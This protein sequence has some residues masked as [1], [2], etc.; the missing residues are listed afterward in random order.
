MRYAKHII[1]RIEQNWSVI[2]RRNSVDN[3]HLH[4]AAFSLLATRRFVTF[5]P[6]RH[7]FRDSFSPPP[8]LR[9]SPTG[10]LIAFV[11]VWPKLGMRS[12]LGREKDRIVVSPSP[13][14]SPSLA[15]SLLSLPPPP[16]FF[17]LHRVLVVVAASAPAVTLYTLPHTH[18]Y[19]GGHGH[20][21]IYRVR[22]HSKSYTRP[23]ACEREREY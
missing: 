2:A 13:L 9:L 18:M 21:R 14:P 5:G 8:L 6:P 16:Q 19:T 3:L 7:E 22:P 12:V 1:I 11:S 4:S 20:V 23:Y 17:S 15:S 10:T